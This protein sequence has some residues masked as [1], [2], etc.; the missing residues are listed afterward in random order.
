[1]AIPTMPGG[2]RRKNIGNEINEMMKGFM[3][4]YK[5][6]NDSDSR[7]SRA[8]ARNP[9]SEQNLA[10]YDS[11][12][13]ST[14][15]GRLF[16]GEQEVTGADRG[17][18][19]LQ[20]KMRAAEER[21][22]VDAWE[23]ANKD[24]GRL[25]KM[26]GS[27]TISPRD[28]PYV[29]PGT[30]PNK[31]AEGVPTDVPMPEPRPKEFAG[32]AVD[33]GMGDGSSNASSQVAMADPLYN[34]DGGYTPDYQI[35]AAR[36]GPVPEMPNRLTGG[37]LPFD[38]EAEVETPEPEFTTEGNN[39]LPTDPEELAPYAAE[40]VDAGYKKLSSD[41]TPASALSE[42]DPDYQARV[43]EYAAKTQRM[44]DD[45]I[46]ELDR[47]IDP[48]GTMPQANRGVARM[49]AAYKF[50]KDKGEDERAA[51]VA[52]R[53][54]QYN[55]FAGGTRAALGAQAIQ[56]GKVQEGVKLLTDAYEQ[57][58]PDGKSVEAT[59]NP[60]N[61]VNISIGYKRQ[62]ADGKISLSPVEQRTIPLKD[63]PQYAAYLTDAGV[64]AQQINIGAGAN[65]SAAGRAGAVG[66]GQSPAPTRK[67]VADYDSAVK[68]LRALPADATEEQREAAY[69]NAMGAYRNAVDS[70]QVGKNKSKAYAAQ[71]Y[72]VQPPQ[73]VGAAAPAATTGART[74]GGGT[75]KEEREAAAIAGAKA[76]SRNQELA[77][78]SDRPVSVPGA[79]TEEDSILARI[80]QE[81]LKRV[82]LTQRSSAKRKPFTKDYEERVEPLA[83]ALDRVEGEVKPEAKSGKADVSK[84]SKLE[85]PQRRRFLRIADAMVAS[86]DVDPDLIVE[87]VYNATHRLS[88]DAQPRVVTDREG[89]SF[90]RIG[91]EQFV[92]NPQ[93][94]REL[95]LM[96]N[97]QVAKSRSEAR[98]AL[99]EKPALP[100]PP[101]PRP[102]PVKPPEVE[103]PVQDYSRAGAEA[104]RNF[105][106]FTVPKVG[107]SELERMGRDAARKYGYPTE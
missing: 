76:Q 38:D 42:E 85:G 26:Q 104:V 74:S 7:Q 32:A 79:D 44:T 5:L 10:K 103:R 41:L 56:Q 77:I 99:K 9:Y 29:E 31:R 91:N 62:G 101:P 3:Q 34:E 8:D 70:F 51:D 69:Q 6:F 64:R 96:R 71:Q 87:S 14:P 28:V 60:D 17:A 102:S 59:V 54:I 106:P 53:L 95:A 97:E 57:N 25:I 98:A 4:G 40:A 75:S 35:F 92:V 89:N 20:A 24:L 15:L 107:A 63:L 46:A 94:F 36:G 65:K 72:G 66:G 37:A 80:Q 48:D 49:A 68:A 88:P 22:D 90:L 11:R 1:M 52:A 13:N 30:D 16:R 105:S 73:R 43:S 58:V 83:K 50:F 23:K 47:M 81:E 78:R 33:D 18:L 82:D 55:E 45:E 67:A 2:K 21:G 61:T 93:T 100:A 12:L 86:N 19:V 84:I 39:G 27:G